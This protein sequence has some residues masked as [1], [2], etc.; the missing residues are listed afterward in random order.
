MCITTLDASLSNTYVGVWDIDHPDWGYRH[1]LAYENTPKNLSDAPNCMLLHIPSSS[2]LLPDHI[3][4]TEN[5]P[6]FLSQMAKSLIPEESG[7]AR[8]V[9]FSPKRNFVV[10][11]GIYHLALLNIVN[12]EA[13]Q[14]ALES[15]PKEKR[16]IISPDFMQFYA[17]TFPGF[18]LLLCCFNN[19]EA[20]KASPIM[21]HFAPLFPDTF[22]FPTLE[23]HGQ[24]P[25]VGSQQIFHQ[26]I[27]TGSQQLMSPGN[28]FESFDLSGISESLLPFLPRIG[29]ALSLNGP[30]P[31]MDVLL[32]AIP[33][34]EEGNA[35]FD[36]GILGTA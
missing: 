30:G 9:D 25:E 5:D 26:T 4:N 27:V 22:L 8:T 1:V 12:E 11:M 21:V 23:S 29:A 24:V 34:R 15:I 35:N 13:L 36:Y 32:E 10:E 7:Y 28:G 16:P 17:Q 19:K 14:E 31:N 6:T 33:V 3:I 20:K 18:P 2:S